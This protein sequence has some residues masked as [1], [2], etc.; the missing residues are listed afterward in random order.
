MNLKQFI[1]HFVRKQ[2]FSFALIT[3]F[4]LSWVFETLYWPYFLGKLVDI[5]NE[6]DSNRLASWGSIKSFLIMGAFIWIFME[7][8]FRIRDFLQSIFHPRLES[9]IRMKMFDHVQRH[10][11]KYFNEHFSGSLANKIEN[12]ATAA[13]II[14]RAIPH[15]YIPA[16]FTCIITLFIFYSINPTFALIIGTWLT[17]HFILSY[18]L[19]RKCDHYSSLH[20]E[21]KSTLVGKIVDSFT[22]NFAVN[23]F[24]RFNYEKEHISSYQKVE[25]KANLRSQIYTTTMWCL[26]STLFI[27]GTFTLT[28]FLVSHWIKGKVST[29]DAVQILYTIWNVSF[30]LYLVADKSPEFFQAIGMAKQ[31]FSLMQEPQDIVDPPHARPL[32][33]KQ[34]A[35]VF[36]NVGFRYGEKAIF[37]NHNLKIEPGEK[38]GLVGYSGAG[39]STFV[40][41][42]LRFYHPQEGRILIDGEDIS[43]FTF[44]SLRTQIS[45]IPQDPILFHRTLEENIRYGRIEATPDEIVDAAKL[46]HSDEFIKKSPQGYLSHVGERGTKLSG[47]EKQRIAIAR[48]MLVKSPIL[49]L[50]EATSSLDSVTENYIQDSLEKLMKERTTIVVAHRLSTLSKMDRILV[51]HQGKIIEEGSHTSLLDKNGHYAHMW[52]MQ[53]GGFLPDS[54]S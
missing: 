2:R 30:V 9:D 14:L 12:M 45:L 35:I 49:I 5:F 42:I 48:A 27:I 47:G 54:P 20:G 29:G 6:F 23:L 39:K 22:N 31:A 15:F 7:I 51:F 33:I 40:N 43:T 21:A 11:P 41:L 17:I 1:L 52:S 4:S 38:I 53:A 25:R 16:L 34:G 8:S 26:L 32:S 18:F 13:S 24:Y 50:D 19:T 44:E 10:S 46:A 36:E 28:G 3:L 37:Q